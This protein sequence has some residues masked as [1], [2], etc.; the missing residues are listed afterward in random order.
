MTSDEGIRQAIERARSLVA[1]EEEPY[2]SIAFQTLLE[3]FLGQQPQRAEARVVGS[4]A[5]RTVRES[6]SINEFLAEVKPR[7]HFDRVVAIA[8]HHYSRGYPQGITL[9]EIVDAY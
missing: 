9:A 6:S 5:P 3:S 2:R 7:S 4:T 1:D 8:Y